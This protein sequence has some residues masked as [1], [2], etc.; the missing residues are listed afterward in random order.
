[1]QITACPPFEVAGSGHH[2]SGSASG[3]PAGVLSSPGCALMAS[4]NAL[5]SSGRII[6]QVPDARGQVRGLSQEATIP[7]VSA[8][9]AQTRSTYL[10]HYKT[11]SECDD[12]PRRLKKN[13][14]RVRECGDRPTDSRWDTVRRK[15]RGRPCS[16]R[17]WRTR[18][19]DYVKSPGA[20]DTCWGGKAPLFEVRIFVGCLY[21]ETH[22][23]PLATNRAPV[24][25]AA[26]APGHCRP[27]SRR[28]S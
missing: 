2:L 8:G 11:M 7:K 25:D 28:H 27:C 9:V 12:L 3:L 17:K 10:G 24:C 23:P 20:A 22:I 6:F 15:A 5:S 18:V 21:A 19:A 16:Y 1:M 26:A 13:H 14:E 4:S